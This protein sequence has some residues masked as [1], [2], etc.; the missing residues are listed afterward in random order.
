[1]VYR[2]TIKGGGV[3]LPVDVALPDGTEVLVALPD[4]WA[5]SAFGHAALREATE[6][7]RRAGISPTEWSSYPSGSPT[8]G[9]DA[10]SGQAGPV[11]EPRGDPVADYLSPIEYA[12]DENIYAAEEAVKAYLNDAHAH[13]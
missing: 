3:V 6:L 10:P 12:W 4:Q 7:G 11:E 13:H 2:G 9:A 1:M 8:P 5:G